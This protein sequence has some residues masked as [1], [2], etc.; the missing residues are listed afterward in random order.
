[1]SSD[2]KI[3]WNPL[4]YRPDDERIECHP[5][6]SNESFEVIDVSFYDDLFDNQSLPESDLMLPSDLMSESELETFLF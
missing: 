6:A 2:M 5:E 3:D 1:M 4:C